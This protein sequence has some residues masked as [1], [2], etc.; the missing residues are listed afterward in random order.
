MKQKKIIVLGA[1]M[2]G[3]AIA[4]DLSKDYHV[5][6][7]DLSM[8][9]LQV[10]K[11]KGIA[12]KRV[13]F[14]EK[15]KLR[16]LVE[17]FD[18]VIG[19]VPG[20]LGFQ[21]LKTVIEA[22]KDIVD[23]SFFP[24]DAFLLNK[25]AQQ[26]GV[27]ALVDCGVAPGLSSMIAGYHHHRMMVDS[28]ACY[29]GGLPKE[30]KPPFE[31]KAPFSPVD[32][33]EE[34]LRPARMV[35][36]DKEVTREAL[37]DIELLKFDGIGELEAFNT[38]GLRTLLRT[39][40]IQ[41]MKEKTLRYP[42]YAEKIRLLRDA[43][44]FSDKTIVINGIKMKPIDFT[45]RV[46]FP[47]WKLQKGEKEF[48]VM[49][50]IVEGN[51]NGNPATYQYDLYDEYDETTGISSMAR[52]TGYTCTAAARL[53]LE[54]VYSQKGISPPEFIGAREECFRFIMQELKKKGVRIT[55]KSHRPPEIIRSSVSTKKSH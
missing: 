2:V 15:K 32:V 38:D 47:Q 39:V 12:A 27:T 49:R 5:T 17:D 52:T 26:K 1:G 11:S 16:I 9:A 31:Y 24:E 7:A 4:L 22:G 28:F 19:A 3:S 48:T 53:V 35:V 50:V 40:D 23:I 20:F 34:Y 54:G 6:A 25:S 45:M 30:R 42:G 51:E 43:G 41:N 13:D 46:L 29:V 36:N 14:S 21:I 44:F 18:L 10:L 33:M 37:S 8:Q 55:V